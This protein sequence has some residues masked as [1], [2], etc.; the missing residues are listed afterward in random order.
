MS[1]PVMLG[2]RGIRDTC[3]PFNSGVGF[4]LNGNDSM[5]RNKS[6]IWF[7]LHLLIIFVCSHASAD[8]SQKSTSGKLHLVRR[9]YIGDIQSP[10]SRDP[11]KEYLKQELEAK[12][13]SIVDDVTTADAILKGTIT[14]P[15]VED[16]WPGYMVLYDKLNFRLESPSNEHIWSAKVRV[17]SQSDSLKNANKRARKLAERIERDWKKSAMK[18]GIKQ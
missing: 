3:A 6:F 2:C 10:L 17:E 12:G 16:E 8:G 7:A 4:L 11:F 5:N 14:I 15:L 9:I 1:E 18:A 13:F